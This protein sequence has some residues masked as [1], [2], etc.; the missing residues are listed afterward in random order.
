MDHDELDRAFERFV[1]GTPASRRAF[2]ARAGATGLSLT[3]LS[4]FLSACGSIKGTA[5]QGAGTVGTGITTHKKTPIDTLHISNWPLYIDK[6]VNK[7]FVKKFGVK[8]FKY[9]EDINEN[10]EFFG[11]V[12]Q[13]LSKGKDIGR[14]IMVLTD[15]MA[16]RMVR[17][18]YTE[19][20]DKRNIP[21]AKNLQ[22]TLAIPQWDPNRAFSLPW[23]SG[24]TGIG[25][26]KKKTGR[27]IKSFKD[28]FDPK[29][30]G[31]VSFLGDPRDASNFILLMNGIKPED[32]K[33]DDVLKAIDYLDKQNKSGQI[34][35]FTGNDYTADLT[36]GN[37]WLCQAYSGDVIQLQAD[38]PDLEFVIP[39]EGATLWSDNMLIPRHAKDVYA[40]E[41]YMN[42]VYDPVVA[43][44][45][46]AYVNYVTPVVGAREVLAKS[47][48]KLA[49]NPLIFPSE[50]DLEQLHP[51]PVLTSDE[52]R[53]MNEAF[54][55]VV[56]A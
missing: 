46:A 25:Y 33:L 22:P 1:E 31:R 10:E 38:N 29:F 5:V 51:F 55:A 11:K 43:A 14:D 36:K 37:L 20:L 52:E 26:N 34:R 12:Q 3:G 6:S 16:A 40:A 45:I 50:K 56:G 44:K 53:Q 35:R 13:P 7:A 30:K 17:L 39:E 48:P 23:Q 42:Y 21:N 4:A 47:D 19:P 15:W 24:M 54:Q 2:L 9:T 18:G 49:S 27:E 28:L 32:A 8:D 41:T